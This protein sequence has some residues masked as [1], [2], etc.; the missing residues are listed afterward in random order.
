MFCDSWNL[1]QFIFIVIYSIFKHFLFYMEICKDRYFSLLFFLAVIVI[2]FLMLKEVTFHIVV[3]LNI[4][5]VFIDFFSIRYLT[6]LLFETSVKQCTKYEA[7]LKKYRTSAIKGKLQHIS[8]HHL[9][10]FGLVPKKWLHRVR[11]VS[12]TI[13]LTFNVQ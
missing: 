12:F 11:S 5:V 13:F 7:W 8:I 6:M 3:A 4:F 10:S 9:I 1:F 2:L